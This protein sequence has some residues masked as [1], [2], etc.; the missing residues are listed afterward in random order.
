M[1]IINA[2]NDKIKVKVLSE[3]EIEKYTNQL[4]LYYRK[5]GFPNYKRN[6]ND[7][8]RK[9]NRIK[10]IDEQS[11]FNSD[12]KIIKKYSYFNRF[13][14]SYFPHWIEV[15]CGNS[16]SLKECWDDDNKLKSLI[17]KTLIWIQKHNEN[18]S[19]NR[20][21]QNAKIFC[22]GQTVS[23]FNPVAAKYLYNTY[24]N[25]GEIL[26]MCCG[27]GGRLLG[28]YGSNCKSYIGFEPS[29]KTYEGLQ[30][31]INDISQQSP[32]KNVRI[33]NDGVENLS[34]YKWINHN[35]DFAFTSPP[36]FNCEKYSDEPTQSYIKYPSKES[37]VDG[38]LHKMFKE[39]YKVL[40]NNGKMAINISNTSTHK[41]IE[42]ECLR[43]ANKASF[44]LVNTLHYEISGMGNKS[45]K[46][47]PIFIFE[48]A[49]ERM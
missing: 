13:L 2:I 29:I 47:E 36:Y 20:I 14:F 45:N 22:S 39:V 4:F 46:A 10:N 5:V 32:Y 28:F 24:G 43:V 6:L 18:W 41:W 40:K 21:R 12:T 3:F 17:R 25:G 19:E 8:T 7:I 48:K 26:D 11:Y 37:W 31:I 16:K 38:F 9:F 35:I 23:N 42:D 34:Q 15:Q 27:W 30:N 33:I 1:E 49:L 44:R